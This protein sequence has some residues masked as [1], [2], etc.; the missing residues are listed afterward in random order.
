MART[1]PV[2]VRLTEAELERL[3]KFIKAYPFVESRSS[4]GQRAILQYIDAMEDFWS[5]EVKKRPQCPRE[6]CVFYRA[7]Y[8]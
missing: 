2:T 5:G 4:V 8:K 6:E 1:E 7:Y 3:D